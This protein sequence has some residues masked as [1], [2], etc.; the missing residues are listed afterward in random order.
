MRVFPEEYTSHLFT[1][2]SSHKDAGDRHYRTGSYSAAVDDYSRAISSLSASTEQNMLYVCY[3]N[4][5]A[6]FLQL[7]RYQEA[8]Y[9]AQ[10]CVALKVDWPKG[11][12]RL[13]SCYSRMHRINDAIAAYEKALELD[14]NNT[15][16]LNALT[17][18]R[19][20]RSSHSSCNSSQS[21]NSL[22]GYVQNMFYCIQQHL[23][24]LNS[25]TIFFRDGYSKVWLF[26]ASLTPQTRQYIQLGVVGL[27]AYYFFFYLSTGSYYGS[28]G[29]QDAYSYGGGGLSWTTWAAVMY[30]AYKLPPMFPDLFGK[31]LQCSHSLVAMA[32]S[33]TPIFY[34]YSKGTMRGPSSACAGPLSCGW[35]ACSLRIAAEAS[36]AAACIAGDITSRNVVDV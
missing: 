22:F 13:G 23:Q 16:A 27:L 33:L 31:L 17:Q 26:W 19:S 29:Y 20:S 32:W 11:Y 14:T 15:D 30:G 36:G 34:I 2:M 25:A 28:Y 35:S 21:D 5:C 6:C 8:L 10:K 12:V 9:D 1:S 7:Q 24:G 3:S 4:R 18:L